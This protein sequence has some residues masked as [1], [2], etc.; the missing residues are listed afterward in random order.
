MN[1]I[2][3]IDSFKSRIFDNNIVNLKEFENLCLILKMHDKSQS[4]KEKQISYND[5][6]NLSILVSASLML[7][8]E[9]AYEHLI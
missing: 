4:L 7:S 1:E 6:T 2:L 8:I 3:N 9:Y 5:F